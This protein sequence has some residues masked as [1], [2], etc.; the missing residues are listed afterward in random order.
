MNALE[1]EL[2]PK[3]F[4]RASRSALV[5]LDQVAEIEHAEASD[6]ILRLRDNSRVPLTRGL[7][8][9]QERLEAAR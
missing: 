2:D 6:F 8:E 1:A 3:A 7:R 5:Q 9:I 4:F